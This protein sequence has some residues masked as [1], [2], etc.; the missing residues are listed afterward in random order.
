MGHM[1]LRLAEISRTI[2]PAELGR[3]LRVARVAAGMTQ[4]QV[5]A[6]DITAAYLSRIEDGQ[7]RP[8]AGLLERMAGRL[9]V[10]LHELLTGISADRTR[11]LQLSLDHAEM[12]LASGDHAA[13]LTLASEVLADT[14]TEVAADLK[15]VAL[16]VQAGAF[17]AAGDLN[18]AI[19]ILEELTA[20]PTADANWLRSLIALSR[21]YRDSGEFA[22]AVAVG[23]TAAATITELGIEGLTEAIQLTVTVAAAH[24][25]L[26]DLD[27]AMRV[28]MR[29]LQAA[30]TYD[31]PVAKASAYWNASVI[32][33]TARGAT[34]LATD[35]ARKA[36]ALFEAADDNRN[37]AKV[38]AEVASLQLSQDPPDGAAA[39]ETLRNAE[40]E[41]AWSGASAW[42]ISLL[43]ITRGRAHL[44]IGEHAEALD[45]IQTGLELAPA[46]APFLRASADSLKGRIAAAEGR[47]DDARALYRNAV[48]ELT[49]AGSDRGAAQLWFD[50]ANLLTEVGDTEGALL[51][52][53]SAGASTGLRANITSPAHAPAHPG[54]TTT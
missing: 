46:Q 13:A 2:D 36:L 43:H 42:E 31:S 37:L 27:E 10:G 7:R 5:A 28:C 22:R 24:H 6:D 3:R 15:A 12:S 25:R 26:G 14:E 44:A 38:R 41:L 30:E 4:A 40:R 32:E 45:S 9:G 8:E 33:N 39:L 48:M 23:D 19:V 21:C 20:T 11:A 51:A 49:A 16:R 52:F 29:A 50:L 54:G 18:G 34:V 35:M 47:L 1:D 53:R 17:E